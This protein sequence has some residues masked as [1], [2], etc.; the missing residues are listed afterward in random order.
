[1]SQHEEFMLEAIRLARQ[2]MNEN[3]GGP[4]G[5]VIVKDHQIIASGY[6]SVL[7]SLDPTAHAEIT[8]IRQACQKLQSFQLTGCTLYTSC[9]PCPMCL[10]AIYWARPDRIYYASSRK[11]AAYAGFDDEFI[12][13]EIPVATEK[14]VIPF[15]QLKLEHARDIF[16]EWINKIDKT[17]Y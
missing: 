4:F 12:Y 1:M 3:Q 10:G 15:V 14:R 16:R 11:D 9:E 7:S 13:R 5:C 2:G 6:N 17:E 8:A